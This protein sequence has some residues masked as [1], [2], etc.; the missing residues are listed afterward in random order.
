MALIK[1]D[2]KY[3]YIEYSVQPETKKEL[4]DILDE[5]SQCVEPLC[6]WQMVSLELIPKYKKAL[7][8]N[9]DKLE[10]DSDAK[11]V[12][13]NYLKMRLIYALA[14]VL[15]QKIENLYVELKEDKCYDIDANAVEEKRNKLQQLV[16]FVNSSQVKEIIGDNETGFSN[17]NLEIKNL[18]Y[19]DDVFSVIGNWRLGDISGLIFRQEYKPILDAAVNCEDPKKPNF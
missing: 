2:K 18:G 5:A 14:N 10:A 9:F 19:E 6:E 4:K 15:H 17:L 12:L 7:P 11:K 16:D 8:E 13:L 3:K 1:R